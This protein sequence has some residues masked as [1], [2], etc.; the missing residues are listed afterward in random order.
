MNE[1]SVTDSV[2]ATNYSHDCRKCGQALPL[3]AL[4]CD[5]CRNLVH[6]EE[7]ERLSVSARIFEKHQQIQPARDNWIKALE[8]LPA[9]SLQSE[10]IRKHVQQLELAQKAMRP[11]EPENPWISR[12]GPFAA[13]AAALLK[14]KTLLALFNFKFLISLAAFLAFYLKAYG[15][16]FGL[17]FVALI[18]IHEMGHFIH[19]RLKGLPADMPVFLPGLGAYVRW[20][21]LGVT[22][23]THAAV[24]LSG[25]MAGCIAA[26]A[27]AALWKISGNGLWG[28]LLQVGS[29]LSILNLIPVWVLDGSKAADILDKSERWVLLIACIILW[30]YLGHGVFLFIA[31]GFGY[32]LFI[33]DFP[34]T[35]NRFMTIYYVSLLVFSGVLLWIAPNHE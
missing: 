14:G 12:L 32:R 3:S 25:P 30:H 24:S 35:P 34:E 2:S 13:I 21:A 18:V 10:W 23:E 5:Q 9:D 15:I 20:E 17:G 27:C 4:V 11:A 19:I 6:Q 28:G 31:A 16:F 29:L 26:G 1:Q 8:L 22:K 7:L 33:R